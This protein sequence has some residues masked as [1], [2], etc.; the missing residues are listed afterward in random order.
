MEK[1]MGTG[2]EG[3]WEPAG[4]VVAV[5]CSSSSCEDYKEGKRG[6]T[7]K[8]RRGEEEQTITFSSDCPALPANQRR[9]HHYYYARRFRPGQPSRVQRA[10]PQ[11]L[12]GL[13]QALG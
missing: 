9:F 5:V 4:L 13:S 11:Q 6:L 8:G 1:R 2:N 12:M 10:G 3:S 7:L